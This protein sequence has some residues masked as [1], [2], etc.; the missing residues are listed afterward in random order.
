ML[1]RKITT[2]VATKLEGRAAGIVEGGGLF[3]EMG[4]RKEVA[5][6]VDFRAPAPQDRPLRGAAFCRFRS[7]S[8]R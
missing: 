1:S 8:S 3:S 5:G 4:I 2:M 7:Y 6:F